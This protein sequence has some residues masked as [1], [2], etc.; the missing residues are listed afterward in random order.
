[1]KLFKKKMIYNI[2]FPEIFFKNRGGGGC[3]DLQEKAAN[4]E[5]SKL[6]KGC[7]HQF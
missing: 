5:G 6:N 3:G 7:A 1:M 4:L 2:E